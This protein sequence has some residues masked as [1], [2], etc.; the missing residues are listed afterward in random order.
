[1]LNQQNAQLTSHEWVGLYRSTEDALLEWVVSVGYL[2]EFSPGLVQFSIEFMSTFP[3]STV[4]SQYFTL[5]E[6]KP[7]I[8]NATPPMAFRG[9]MARVR[10]D[11]LTRGSNQN[12]IQFVLWET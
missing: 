2:K 12:S 5:M 6:V 1:M 9:W 10:V 11:S 3:K 8:E 4:G 7:N